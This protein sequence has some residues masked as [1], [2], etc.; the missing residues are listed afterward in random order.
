[1]RIL[2]GQAVKKKKTLHR[3]WLLRSDCLQKNL[4][5]S[6]R[7]LLHC[8]VLLNLDIKNTHSR[9]H[10]L[11]CVK[12]P[13]NTLRLRTALVIYALPRAK[14]MGYWVHRFPLGLA[15]HACITFACMYSAHIIILHRCA[16]LN[17]AKKIQCASVLKAAPLHT[18][19]IT[20][21]LVLS[22]SVFISAQD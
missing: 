6:T 22:P 21:R 5:A 10:A 14:A 17:V 20:D 7:A 15:Q 8:N 3:A 4:V 12:N 9:K 2:T 11:A 1:M 13:R 18:Q 19:K 16:R